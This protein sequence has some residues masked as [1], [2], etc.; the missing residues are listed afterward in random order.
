MIRETGDLREMVD[1]F[2]C[3]MRFIEL[4]RQIA[5]VLVAAGAQPLARLECLQIGHVSSARPLIPAMD[6]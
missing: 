5:R 2:A 1:I 3:Y 6:T 4:D